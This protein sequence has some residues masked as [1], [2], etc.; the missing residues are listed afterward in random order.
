MLFAF[1][2]VY[3]QDGTGYSSA[4]GYSPLQVITLRYNGKT[5][6][7]YA[8][9]EISGSPFL[10][11][12]WK[13]GSILLTD[14]KS[15]GNIL[16][17]YDVLNNKFLF[18]N[19]DSIYEFLDVLQQVTIADTSN[20]LNNEYLIFQKINNKVD[21]IKAGSFVQILCNG[22]VKLYKQ[23][24]KKIEG[25]NVDNGIYTSTKRIVDYSSFWVGVNNEMFPIK[26]NRSSLEQ[27]PLDKKEEIK[28]YISKKQLKLN[29][30]KD[31]TLAIIYYNK[32]I[33]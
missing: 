2:E 27:L 18:N 21:K 10:F 6:S 26:L 19:K 24:F 25:Q 31:F 30:E 1:K 17:K 22:K 29:K 5:Y 12:D 11:D 8:R 33:E 16:L 23:H 15:Y 20:S 9:N 13:P 32:L 3:C 7:E 28:N 14:G 4:A